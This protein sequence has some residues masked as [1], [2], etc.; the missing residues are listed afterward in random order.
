MEVLAE[1][2]NFIVETPKERLK[3]MRELISIFKISI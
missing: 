3:T 1:F 2:N